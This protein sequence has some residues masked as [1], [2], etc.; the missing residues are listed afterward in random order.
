MSNKC[1]VYSCSSNCKS[2]IKDYVYVTMYRF[3]FKLADH[4]L[5][6]KKLPNA[7]FMFTNYK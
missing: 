6:I 1:C 7:N 4:E 2:K 3:L 5:W